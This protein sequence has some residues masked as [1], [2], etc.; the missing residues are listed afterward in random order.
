M[1]L[2][3]SAQCSA[4]IYLTTC[5]DNWWSVCKSVYQRIK[6]AYFADAIG[7]ADVGLS[8]ASKEDDRG[9]GP[10][11]IFSFNRVDRWAQPLTYVDI[12]EGKY[13]TVCFCFFRLLFAL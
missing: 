7:P 9:H 2:V 6:R 11:G 5:P 13:F 4:K 12:H 10:F 8:D 3:F 1:I